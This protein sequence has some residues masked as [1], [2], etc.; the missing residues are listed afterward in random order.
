MK[1]KRTYQQE[2]AVASLN[3][4]T[5]VSGNLSRRKI[6]TEFTANGVGFN[7]SLTLIQENMLITKLGTKI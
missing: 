6:K 1:N 2:T 7:K 4:Q 5:T 3:R